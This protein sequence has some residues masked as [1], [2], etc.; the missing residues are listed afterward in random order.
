MTSTYGGG[1]NDV[2]IANPWVIELNYRNSFEV[3]ANE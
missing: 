2:H 3:L 1:C